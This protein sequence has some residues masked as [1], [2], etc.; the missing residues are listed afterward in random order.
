MKGNDQQLIQLTSFPRHHTREEHKQDG[1]ECL[2]ETAQA[3]IQEVSSFPAVV[4]Q[5]IQNKMKRLTLNY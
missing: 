2:G 3:K 5:A 1:I 4:H